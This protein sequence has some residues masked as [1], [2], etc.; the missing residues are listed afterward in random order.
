[1]GAAVSND[2]RMRAVRAY[3]AGE[4]TFSELAELFAVGEA[5]L[6]RWAKRFR[7]EGTVS[8]SPHAGGRATKISDEDLPRLRAFVAEAPDRTVDELTAAWRIETATELSRSAMLRAL[9]R[10]GL[11]FKKKPSARRSNSAKTSSSAA[12]RSRLASRSSTPT[13]WSSSTSRAATSR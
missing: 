6:R 10:A 7:N 3:L 1:M 11:T 9:H 5:S 2:L 4:G 13:G 12:R 8:P